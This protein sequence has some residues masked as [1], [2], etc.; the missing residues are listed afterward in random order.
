MVY[1]T[2]R[3]ILSEIKHIMDLKDISIKEL[4]AKLN[5]SQQNLSRIL[6]GTNT[7]LNTLF[8]I[9]DSLDLEI[10]ITFKSK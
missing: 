10:D 4:A 5:T 7:Q 8:K 3:E 1:K 2:T 6:N 9:C